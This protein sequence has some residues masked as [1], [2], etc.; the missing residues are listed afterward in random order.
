MGPEGG[1]GGAEGIAGTVAET[2]EA[3]AGAVGV[4]VPIGPTFGRVDRGEEPV[5]E[6]TFEGRISGVMIEERRDT[7]ELVMEDAT[8]GDE[9]ITL[10][11]PGLE[12]GR[13][14]SATTSDGGR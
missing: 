3:V 5:L 13:K 11:V 4:E 10:K 14:G 8:K 1:G 2:V 9:E 6:P 12:R 7:G